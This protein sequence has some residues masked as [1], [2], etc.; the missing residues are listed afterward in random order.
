VLS[1]IQELPC[2]TRQYCCPSTRVLLLSK[3]NPMLFYLCCAVLHSFLI[4]PIRR[5][6]IIDEGGFAAG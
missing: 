2:W 3:L 4:G 5:I 1:R 6:D